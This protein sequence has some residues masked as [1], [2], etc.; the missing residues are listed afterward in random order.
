MATYIKKLLNYSKIFFR[1]IAKFLY[2]DG[3]R[4]IYQLKIK[5]VSSYYPESLYLSTLAAK[6]KVSN[7]G[8][9]QTLS[10]WPLAYYSEALYLS[11]IVEK[12]FRL[13]IKI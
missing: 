1:I 8:L 3:H 11:K 6:N 10:T 5:Q 9:S 13:K 12:V 7:V 4:A 2:Y